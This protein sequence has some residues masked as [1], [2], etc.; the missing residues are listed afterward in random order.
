MS[1]LISRLP[2]A[3][4]RRA[5]ECQK[6]CNYSDKKT[7]D[8][9]LSFSWR[10]TKEGQLIWHEVNNGD[11]SRFYTFHNIKPTKRGRPKKYNEPTT[12]IAFRVPESKV[13]PITTLV[14]GKLK[15]W[16]VK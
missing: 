15:E 1:K 12:T 13:K 5:L 16:E 8:L 10:F 9:E 6:E 3:I 11:Y 4:R 7:D 14:N 2:M